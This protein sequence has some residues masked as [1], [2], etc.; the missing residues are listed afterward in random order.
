MRQQHYRFAHQVL[1]NAVVSDPEGWWQRLSERGEVVLGPAWSAA[2]K[3]L[4]AADQVEPV[5]L[6]VQERAD[7]LGLEAIL[8][9]LPK[10]EAPNE[11]FF[12]ALVRRVG[13]PI[14]YF[15]LEKGFDS[16]DGIPRA[17]WAE[18]RGAAG[19]TMRIRGEDIPE[20]T[21]N[22]FLTAIA[23]ELE[24]A[25]VD[26][27]TV[28]EPR[29]GTDSGKHG[30]TSSWGAPGPYSIPPETTPDGAGG[31]KKKLAAMGCGGCLLVFLALAVAV[32]YIVYLEE[33]QPLG[34]P[35]EE[36]KTLTIKPGKPF[37][38]RFIWDGTNYASNDIWLVVKGRKSNGAFKVGGEIGCSRSGKI[39]KQ[40]ID[41]GL[42]GYGVARKKRRGKKGRFSAWIRIHDEYARSSS[43]PFRCS[44][45][46]KAKKGK[47]ESAKIVVTRRQRPSDFFAF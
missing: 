16:D 4:D 46:I 28:P 17:F 11:C 31:G 14:R 13:G 44:G 1:M 35:G 45:E 27:A 40:E 15:V 23:G 18:W 3:D 34:E 41:A 43:R 39:R 7:V 24:I 5:G 21:P 22:G 36:V 20:V 10:P 42:S 26:A 29:P 19:T 9:T 32:G 6:S 38:L 8:I 25:G 37:R 30:D 12:I 33:G 2:G 47:I